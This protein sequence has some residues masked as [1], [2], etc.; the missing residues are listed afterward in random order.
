MN[1]DQFGVLERE[2]LDAFQKDFPLEPRPYRA[3]ADRLGCDEDTVLDLLRRLKEAGLVSR[4]GPVFAPHQAGASTLAAMAVPVDRLEEVAA[5]VTD[6]DEV[7]HNYEREHDF[8]LWFVLAAPDAY[9]I[10]EVLREIESRTGIS[11]MNLPLEEAF[12]IDLGFPLQWN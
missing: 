5:L 3:I 10:V 11:V 1:I 12:H 4:V 8:N 2:L 9:R 6:Y 7:N